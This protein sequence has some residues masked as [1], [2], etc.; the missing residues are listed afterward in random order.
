MTYINNQAGYGPDIASYPVKISRE[1]S[2]EVYDNSVDG[3]VSGQTLPKIVLHLLDYD[4]QIASTTHGGS[5]T[6][7]RIGSDTE[8]SGSSSASI[9]NGVAEFIDLI[10]IAPPG[11]KNV[12]FEMSSSR[13]DSD[14]VTQVL[15]NLLILIFRK[16]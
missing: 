9:I 8:V 13:I 3:L 16:Q 11:S 12:S 10:L 2:S 6:I 14:I 5:V 1:I 4:N 15:G 7:S